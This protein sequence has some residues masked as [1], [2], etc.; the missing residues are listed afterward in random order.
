ML[1]FD[2]DHH[3]VWRPEGYWLS[4]TLHGEGRPRRLR[5]PL[6]TRDRATARERRD[7]LLRT[8]PDADVLVQRPQAS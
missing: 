5:R 1:T 6:G 4:I 2:P 7:R 3:L 8:L